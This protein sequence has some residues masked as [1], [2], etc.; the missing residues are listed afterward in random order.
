M[1]VIDASVA[2]KWFVDE[3]YSDRASSVRDANLGQIAVPDLFVIEVVGALVRRAN[4]AKGLRGDSE[5]AIG[6]LM[7]LLDENLITAVPASPPIV[8]AAAQFALDL[9]HP[10]KDCVYLALAADLECDLVTCDAR[11]AA[12]A[13]TLRPVVALV[14]AG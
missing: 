6:T 1:I 9:G 4:M 14:E 13:R 10:F 8:S 5:Q 7:A 11:F 3:D 2:V 12:K